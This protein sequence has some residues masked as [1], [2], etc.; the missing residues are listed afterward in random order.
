MIYV[1]PL[2]QCPQGST[3][4]SNADGYYIGKEIL[5]WALLVTMMAPRKMIA[6]TLKQVWINHLNQT[7]P[8]SPLS[9]FALEAKIR[10]GARQQTDHS[11]L[12]ALPSDHGSNH[13]VLGRRSPARHHCWGWARSWWPTGAV[14]K[15]QICF[16]TIK[17]HK[18]E[19]TQ[20]TMGF[21]RCGCN[22]LQQPSLFSVYDAIQLA[23]R[24]SFMN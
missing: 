8:I 4:W 13:R 14:W 22:N 21:F 11:P 10:N 12:V 24:P 6:I 3:I 19:E 2:F 20:T 18:T 23:M 15:R 16:W 17:K 7:Q 5:T 9:K 1:R